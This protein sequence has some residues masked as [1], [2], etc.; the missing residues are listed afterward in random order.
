MSEARS[1]QVAIGR[2]LLRRARRLGVIAIGFL[3]LTIGL[4]LAVLPMIPGGAV[5]ILLGLTILSTELEWARRL[6]TRF[7]TTGRRFLPR[8]FSRSPNNRMR[9]LGL[10]VIIGLA[11]AAVIVAVM[12]IA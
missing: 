10:I 6:R 1:E 4:I 7:I 9:L 3:V 8:L 11:M 12:L 2:R 5:G